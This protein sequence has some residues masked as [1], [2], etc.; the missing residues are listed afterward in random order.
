MLTGLEEE[1]KEKEK[2]KNEENTAEEE[3]KKKRKK[4]CCVLSGRCLC[5]GLITRPEDP[6]DYGPSCVI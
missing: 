2:V 6:T 4:E 5:G 1:K 3:K